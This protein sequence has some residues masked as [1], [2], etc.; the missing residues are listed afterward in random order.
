MNLIKAKE[1]HM[2]TLLNSNWMKAAL[3]AALAL[4]VAFV[5]LG[6]APFP[7]LAQTPNS[8][9]VIPQAPQ[10]PAG[11]AAGALRKAALEKAF[12]RENTASSA[13]AANLQ[14]IAKLAT[15]AQDWI[16]KAQA[17]GWDVS[18]LQAALTTFNGQI[19]NA[20]S[21]HNTAAGM[22]AAHAGFDA[23]GKVTD[24]AGAAQTVKDARQSLKDAHGVI[25]QAAADL[26]SAIRTFR[27]AHK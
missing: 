27:S 18:D 1:T 2:K 14:R 10:N 8:G 22:L 9:P 3:I 16:T 11:Q 23:S 13:Q 12:A 7:A 20:Q 24:P 4:G 19:A 6:F 21:L 25:Q 17:K 26:R 5:S 15:T